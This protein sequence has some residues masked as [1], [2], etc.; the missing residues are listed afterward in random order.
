M[1]VYLAVIFI[2]LILGVITAN[3]RESDRL[4]GKYLTASVIPIAMILIVWV[5]VFA[6]RDLTIGSDTNGYYYFYHEIIPEKISLKEFI[7]TQ[8]DWLFSILEYVC[9]RL[10]H[11]SWLGF[12]I[13]VAL[14]IYIPII[15][16]VV[17]KS[18]NIT[19]SLLLFIF[20][21]AY[22]SG[23]NG[24]RQAI[25]CSLIFYAYY[26]KFLRKKYL[27]YAMILLLAFGFHSSVIFVLPVHILSGLNYKS[28]IVRISS[29]LMLVLYFSIYQ[30]WPRII[31]FLQAIGQTKMAQD[32]QKLP[33][34]QG[35]GFLRLLVVIIPV[36][37]GIIYRT[38]VEGR[39][40]KSDGELILCLY[41]ALFML[42]ST[43]YWIFARVSSY[44][45]LSQI[46]YLPKLDCIFTEDNQKLGIFFIL[47]LFFL[48][49]IA[50]LIHGDGGYYPYRFIMM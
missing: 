9:A 20:T 15:A 22:F 23:F 41:G 11:G 7:D 26:Q 6:F 14:L 21:L 24:M 32:Y 34:G 4:A 25:A 35:S 33:V 30:L 45:S 19:A 40:Y 47:L 17:D 43:R 3:L 1:R 12:Q 28:W 48:Y 37:L 36:I 10:F 39:Y 44:F 50:L 31:R 8:R 49:M 2:T 38:R 27:S 42:L 5:Y 46:M 13:V 29:L 18:A 16:V